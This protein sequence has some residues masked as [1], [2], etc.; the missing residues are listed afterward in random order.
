MDVVGFAQLGTL[1]HSLDRLSI[2]VELEL[3][4]VCG[5]ACSRSRAGENV[6]DA[7]DDEGGE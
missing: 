5:I 3:S 6:R 2:L 1:P 4:C 7:D